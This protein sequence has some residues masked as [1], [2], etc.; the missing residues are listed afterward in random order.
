MNNGGIDSTDNVIHG[1]GS[2]GMGHSG[3]WIGDGG[4]TFIGDGG[5]AFIGDGG[6]Q[7]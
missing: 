7:I 3:S 5:S 2:A 6:T 4:T 1:G